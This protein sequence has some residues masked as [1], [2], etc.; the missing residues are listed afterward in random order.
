M[1][2]CLV[3]RFPNVAA[4]LACLTVSAAV[5]VSVHDVRQRP[6]GFGRVLANAT[7]EAAQA[8]CYGTVDLAVMVDVSSSVGASGIAST[9]RFLQALLNKMRLGGG[10]GQ[11]LVSLI[12]VGMTSRLAVRFSGNATVLEAG[13]RSLSVRNFSMDLVQGF[14]LVDDAFASGRASAQATVLLILD[15]PAIRQQAALQLAHRSAAYASLVV[16]LVAPM[17]DSAALRAA[18][19]LLVDDPA[20]AP[21]ATLLRVDSYESLAWCS[22]KPLLSSICSLSATVPS[23][24]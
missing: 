9:Q 22:V 15:G 7:S 5:V 8:P 16:L 24:R 3:R 23:I 1:F 2:L 11:Q 20:T 18:E 12:E 14:M 6:P 10:D 21:K 17:D 4:L 13:V 19:S